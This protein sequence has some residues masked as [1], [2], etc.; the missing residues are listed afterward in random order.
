MTTDLAEQIVGAIG[1]VLLVA[2]IVYYLMQMEPAD[3][4]E[5]EFDSARR[6]MMRPMD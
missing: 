3:A 5:H 2:W 6:K 4:P 1:F